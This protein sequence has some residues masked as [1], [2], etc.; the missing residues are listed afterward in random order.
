MRPRRLPILSL[1]FLVMEMKERKRKEEMM[2]CR[3]ER[4]E[5]NILRGKRGEMMI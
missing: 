1:K 2:G 5:G 4:E 3:N